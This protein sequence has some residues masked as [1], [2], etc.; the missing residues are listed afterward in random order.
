MMNMVNAWT[1]RELYEK[2]PFCAFEHICEE[3][4]QLLEME[5]WKCEYVHFHYFDEGCTLDDVADEYGYENFEDFQYDGPY[6]A[7]FSVGVLVI[8]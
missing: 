8:E 2:L 5:E 7:V 6:S 1:I 3:L 4:P